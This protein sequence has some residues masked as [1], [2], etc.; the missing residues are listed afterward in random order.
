[1]FSH[2]YSDPHFG[3]AN[4]IKYCNRPFSTVQDMNEHL[5][6]RYNEMVSPT[7]TVLWLGDCAMNPRVLDSILPRLNGKRI[8]IVGN[9]DGSQPM[10]ARLGFSLVLHEAVLHLGDRTCRVSHYP[11]AGHKWN[12]F[13][14][15]RDNDRRPQPIKGEV[16]LHGHTHQTMQR[17][18]N[19]INVGVDAWDYGPAPIGEVEELVKACG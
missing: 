14:D 6:A 5:V 12:D 15:N 13:V 8:L 4:I 11:Y 1:M 9:H 2:F 17:I 19:Q 18:N 3:H 16:L 10:M 7:D